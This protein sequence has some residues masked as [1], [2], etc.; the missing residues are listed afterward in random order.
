[1]L[2]RQ[3]GKTG[4]DVSILG[5]GCMRLPVLD[6]DQ[7]KIDTELAT[8]MLHHAIDN[9]VNYVDTAWFYHGSGFSGPGGESEPFVGRALSGGWRDRVNLSTKLPQ[10]ICRETADM[11]R[12]L[13]QQ[14][15]RLQTDHVDFYLV[16]G[17]NGPAWDK[18]KSLG[19]I[20]FLER[21]QADGRI[22]FPAFS[23]HGAAADFIRICDDYDNWAFGQIQYNY[24]DTAFQA[25]RAGLLHAA[26]KGMGVVVM[27]PIKGGKLGDK[28]PAPMRAVFEGRPE[29]WS[30]AEWALRYVWN[31]PGVSLTLSGMTSM[32]HVVDNLAAA[33]KGLP[34]SLTAEEFAV[35][36]KAAETLR[37]NLRA[38]CSRCLYCM[39]C[40][41]G[42]DIPDVIASLNNATMWGDD[43]PFTTGYLQVKGKASNCIECG[44]CLDACPQ[45][46]PIPDLMQEAVKTFGS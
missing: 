40:P 1:M 20:E 45:G 12:F 24:M 16:H 34:N 39:P 15:E 17:L 27:E 43:S 7:T 37:A 36:A 13:T 18:M 33:E 29:G 21:A 8:R 23:F 46:L 4:V 14:L 44:T 35:Y 2:Y 9:G 32:Q 26:E 3:I 25:G 11:D 6:G 10:Q 31:E 19:V 5:F 42:V 30:P 38:D 22:R 41:N 28:M